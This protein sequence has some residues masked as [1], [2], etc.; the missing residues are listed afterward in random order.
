MQGNAAVSL[1]TLKPN[2]QKNLTT[3]GAA[4]AKTAVHARMLGTDNQGKYVGF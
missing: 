2:C 3:T 4:Q 1:T